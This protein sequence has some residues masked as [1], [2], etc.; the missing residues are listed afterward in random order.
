MPTSSCCLPQE[1]PGATVAAGRSVPLSRCCKTA[2]PEGS[3]YL[4]ATDPEDDGLSLAL[5]SA[6][7]PAKSLLCE[8]LNGAGAALVSSRPSAPKLNPSRYC[9]SGPDEY[10]P[11]SLPVHNP[12]HL[13]G[14][15]AVATFE[16]FKGAI[17]LLAGFGLLAFIGKDAQHLAEKFVHR[18]HLNPAHRY[19][20]IFLRAMSHVTDTH[21][22]M[23]AGLA[24]LYAIVRFIE[25]YGLW[26]ARRWA[27]WFAALSGGVYVPIEI[28]EV[29]QKVTW[30][31]VSVLTINL[32]IVAY[33]FWL[34]TESRRLRRLEEKA[35]AEIDQIQD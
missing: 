12:N 26:H 20:E 30:V 19:P 15:R 14:L 5:G 10:L 31:R 6:L 3:P 22:L 9:Q 21:L 18:T 28:Y 2:H 13:K 34:L 35:A 16:A 23:L 33:M 17:V 4:R 11:P 25:A 7:P 32:A 8:I 29:W 24:L 27:E 1:E